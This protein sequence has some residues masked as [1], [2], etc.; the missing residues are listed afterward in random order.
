MTVR[1]KSSAIDSVSAC[2]ECMIIY[3]GF[4]TCG[5]PLSLELTEAMQEVME[6]MHD[7]P[8]CDGVAAHLEVMEVIEV[9]EL[10]VIVRGGLETRCLE[11]T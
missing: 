10:A 4:S 6:T 2:N 9:A 11:E 7:L 3:N 1:W 8:M 5:E